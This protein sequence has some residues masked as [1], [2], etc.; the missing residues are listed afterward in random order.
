[1]RFARQNN[2][3]NIF[4]SLNKIAARASEK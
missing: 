1:L 4:F 2:F 3:K